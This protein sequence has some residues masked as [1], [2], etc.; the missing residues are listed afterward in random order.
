MN[1]Y[2]WDTYYEVLCQ[3]YKEQGTIN[4]VFGSSFEKNGLA[5]GRWINRQRNYYSKGQL[6]TEKIAKLEAIGFVWNGNEVYAKQLQ[7]KWDAIFAL[8]ESYYKQNGN[9][10]MPRNYIIDGV[11]V[12]AWLSNLKG[13]YRG[14]NNRKLS[15]YQIS[16]LESIGIEWDYDYKEDTWNKMYECAKRYFYEHG[17]IFLPQGYNYEG[18]ALGSWIHHQTQEYK[19]RK[20]AQHKIDKLNELGIRWYPQKDKWNTFYQCA[21]KYYK[22]IGNLDVPDDF[23]FD[24]LNLG[25]WISVQRQ[26]YNGRQDT[27]LNAEQIKKLEAIGMSWKGDSSTQTSFYEQVVF[28]YVS[29]VFPSAINRHKELGIELDIYVPELNLGIEYDG[30]YWHKDKLAQDNQK[31]SLCEKLG[32]SLVRI[33]ECLLPITNSA[34]CFVLTDQSIMT[35]QDT[36]Y[37]VFKE[38]IKTFVPIDIKKDSFEIIKGYKIQASSPWYKAFLEAKDYYNTNGNLIVPVGYITST[39]LDLCK[40]IRRQRQSEKGN[41]RPITYEQISLLDSIGMIWD[42]HAIA[43]EEGYSYAKMYFD[44]FHNLLVSQKCVYRGFK[45]GRWINKQRVNKMR[46]RNTSDRI[47]KL[48]AI[49]MVWDS[50]VAAWE[51]G[52]RQAQEYFYENGN[53]LVHKGYKTRGG[54]SL[55]AWIATQRLLK[56]QEKLFDV[57]SRIDR[58][59]TIGMVWNV[60]DAIWQ[61]KYNIAKSYFE[62]HNNLLVPQECEYKNFKLGEWISSLRCSKT[63]SKEKIEQLNSIGMVWNMDD[64]SWEKHYSILCEYYNEFHTI[65]VPRNTVY[66]DVSIGTWIKNIKYAKRKEKKSYLTDARIRLLEELG[67]QWN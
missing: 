60:K 16:K 28:Y 39:G 38:C 66:K 49:G 2:S 46:N 40:W 37:K 29:K 32:I 27:L 20:L 1:K 53:L 11:N 12:G 35:F 34:K 65:N 55:G 22:E 62:E 21:K 25:R 45:L 50:K 17:N 54:Y 67:I 51:E 18:L 10:R 47:S 8:A 5:I 15:P 19:K 6:N 33:R 13:A 48:E 58:L 23:E 61:H 57:Q 31:D 7:A 64:Y 26:A 9:L 4:L 36:L 30:Y 14:C 56:K 42:P 52:F 41:V 63:L 24:N 3:I 59:D 43:W 44:E